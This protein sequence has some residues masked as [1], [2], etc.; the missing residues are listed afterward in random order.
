MI[1]EAILKVVTEFY[2]DSSDFNGINL[3]SLIDL[4]KSVAQITETDIVDATA[5]LITD[6]KVT[7]T[8]SSIFINPHIKAFPDLPPNEQVARLKKEKPSG[9]CIYPTEKIIRTNTVISDY[10]NKPFTKRLLLGEPQLAPIYF[11]INVLDRYC[12]D[13]RYC[14]NFNDYSGWIS[15][16]DDYFESE[17]M[18]E[19]DK[20]LLETFGIGYDSN[21]NRV[22][23]VFLRYLSDLSPEH[24]QIWHAQMRT[25]DCKMAYEYY[26]NEILVEWGDCIS[27]YQA[28]L[29][30]L[31]ILNKLASLIGKPP[32]FREVYDKRPRGFSLLLRPTL[33]NYLE[34]IHLI[35]KLLS[36]N[37]NKDFFV[38]DVILDVNIQHKDGKIEVKQKGTLQLLSEWLHKTVHFSDEEPY[39][40]ILEPL[41]EVRKIRQKPAHSVIKDEYD[42]KYI[43]QQEHLMEHIHNALAA[44]CFVLSTH[45]LVK[46]SDYTL[47][48]WIKENKVKVY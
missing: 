31:K 27:V 47:P 44:L 32:L 48:Q 6:E 3:N 28:V 45:P 30:E 21:G 14:Y 29:E 43:N 41:K 23:V 39:K 17:Q 12:S 11:E 40:A 22:V 13:P 1:D 4:I 2:L 8:F 9:I 34:F 15:V 24:Q 5:R 35:D 7:L 33:K 36:E 18:P 38:G 19:K 10:D 16:S 25:D 46:A 26:Q 42:S 20:T 37:I